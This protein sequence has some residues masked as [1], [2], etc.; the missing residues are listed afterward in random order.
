VNSKE[1]PKVTAMN[2][3]NTDK[4]GINLSGNNYK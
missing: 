3:G 4:K 2:T 1:E